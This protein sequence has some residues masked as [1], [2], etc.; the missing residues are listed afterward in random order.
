M[1]I[2]VGVAVANARGREESIR[3][4]RAFSRNCGDLQILLPN[5]PPWLGGVAGASVDWW[6]VLGRA[7]DAL[8][9]GA[10]LFKLQEFLSRKE[11]GMADS[12]IYLRIDSSDGKS[13]GL[14]IT[15]K[16]STSQAIGQAIKAAI[17]KVAGSRGGRK[18][19]APKSKL[20]KKS[21]R[22]RLL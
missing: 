4:L 16:L 6:V 8:T 2:Q 10:A 12:E 5:P 15:G 17:L 14:K 3:A 7:A 1:R 21:G 20:S 22:R 13:V 18:K 9:L 11:N 19:T